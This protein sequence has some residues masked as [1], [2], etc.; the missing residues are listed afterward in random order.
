MTRIEMSFRALLVASL[1]L[2]L[3][4]A[5]ALGAT[6]HVVRGAGYGHGVGMS[7]Y[8]AYGF[9]R[10]GSGY[11]A[12]LAH[13][14]R[15]TE[16]G[17]A[18]TRT[19]RVLLRANAS[20]LSFEGASDAGGR[21]L[22]L[23]RRYTVVLREGELELRSGDE[24]LGR[25]V[26]PLT[27]SGPDGGLRLLGRA[28][29][30]VEGGVYRGALELRPSDGGGLTAVN[31]VGLDAYLQGVV[32][33]EVPSTWPE[34]ALRA[35]AVAARSYALAT[36][37]GG[38]LFDHYPDVRSQV[39]RG[40][41]GE[42][43]TTNRAVADTAG[44]VLRYGGFIATT[45]F[46]STSGGRTENVENVFRASGP[47][48]YLVSV[49]DPFDGASPRHRWSLSFTQ[50]QMQR[51]LRGLVKGRFRRVKVTRRGASPR[52]VDAQVM[53]SRGATPV[54]GTV[55]RARLGLPDTWAYFA[56]VSTR[57]SRGA[58]LARVVGR[59][60]LVAEF[61]P[62][63]RRGPVVARRERGRWV[64]AG[65][66]RPRADGRF[67]FG[68]RRPGRYRVVADGFAGPSVRVR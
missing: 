53:G 10:Q 17:Q 46:F 8:G 5:S 1:L 67:S 34:E 68:L 20:A 14:Y 4:P 60:Q 18:D 38:A 19:I 47:K 3:V 22:D 33:G 62:A 9:A 66:L 54:P 52:I 27:V 57:R 24:R 58:R 44:E 64:A 25:F 55:L 16:L 39:Y 11:R 40:V 12:I 65:R 45:F 51:K 15:G 13:Y 35:Q 31:S 36:D 29:N 63:P 26:A 59:R 61:A 43:D 56:R 2:L 23:D 28:L 49:D 48:P 21:R 41:T 32:P 6:R 30:G 42:R 50:R 37:R 7:Q